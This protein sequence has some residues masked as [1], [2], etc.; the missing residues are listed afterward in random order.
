MLTTPEFQERPEDTVKE[1]LGNHDP[2]CEYYER[3]SKQI[4][5]GELYLRMDELID[6]VKE[7]HKQYNSCLLYTSRCV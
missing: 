6:P 1:E 7:T 3:N 2:T 4:E 5:H